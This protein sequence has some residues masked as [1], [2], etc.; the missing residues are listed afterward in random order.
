MLSMSARLS[1]SCFAAADAR[2]PQETTE[3]VRLSGYLWRCS[4]IGVGYLP[5]A[6][7]FAKAYPESVEGQE[8]PRWMDVTATATFLASLGFLAE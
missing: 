7:Y 4:S 6:C 1:A 5:L 2:S 8:S 3:F